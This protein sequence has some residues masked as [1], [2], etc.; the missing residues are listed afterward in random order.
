MSNLVVNDSV[1]S[2][3]SAQ[4]WR[5]YDIEIDIAG[6]YECKNDGEYLI[7][8][9][10]EQ[11]KLTSYLIKCKRFDDKVEDLYLHDGEE[12]IEPTTTKEEQELR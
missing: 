10:T 5:Y 12:W 4:L 7:I 9:L 2:S 8:G 11:Y 6:I 3:I 1:L